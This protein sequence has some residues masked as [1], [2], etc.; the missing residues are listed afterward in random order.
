MENRRLAKCLLV[1]VIDRCWLNIYAPRRRAE[2]PKQ[3]LLVTQNLSKPEM[4][5]PRTNIEENGTALKKLPTVLM[6]FGVMKF[7]ALT[8]LSS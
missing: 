3:S 1:V 5:K 4:K 2:E 6:D 7:L 8:V